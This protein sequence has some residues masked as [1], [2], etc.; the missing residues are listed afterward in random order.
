MK[1]KTDDLPK[2]EDSSSKLDKYEDLHE[3]YI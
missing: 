2:Q 3:C 1:R